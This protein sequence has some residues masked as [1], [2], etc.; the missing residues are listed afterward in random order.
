M[1]SVI[2][3][4]SYFSL[5]ACVSQYLI[6]TSDSPPQLTFSI[7]CTESFSVI[8][9]VYRYWN[10]D[11]NDHFYT[12]SA[13]EIGTTVHGQFGN[14]GYKYEGIQCHIYRHQ[15][16]HS[17]P[18]YRYW[19][20]DSRDHFYTTHSVEIG[21]T[22]PGKTGNH[23]YKSEGVTGYCFP[24]QKPNTIPLYRYWNPLNADHFYTTNRN[25]IGTATAGQK[26]QHGYVSEGV[27][28]YVIGS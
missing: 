21:T 15:V 8:L 5:T 23:G 26:G 1:V 14:H 22:T 6:N 27:V 17:V 4:Y 28:C 2:R 3:P 12:L 10:P 19:K 13:K 16:E 11:A 24:E 25:E 7:L 20:H 18:L 9:P